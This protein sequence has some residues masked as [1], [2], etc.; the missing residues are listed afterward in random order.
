MSGNG[1]GIG[2]GVGVE[3]N[4]ALATESGTEGGV[5]TLGPYVHATVTDKN[6]A[7]IVSRTRIR[8]LMTS[9]SLILLLEA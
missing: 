3:S 4:E 9:L 8:A 7:M 2:R 1:V 5:V 6:T